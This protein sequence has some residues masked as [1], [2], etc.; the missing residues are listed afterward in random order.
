MLLFYCRFGFVLFFGELFPPSMDIVLVQW[1]AYRL[2][3][4][5]VKQFQCFLFK[6]LGNVTL[7]GCC[8]PGTLS[9]EA[10]GCYLWT[11]FQSKE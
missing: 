6:L 11:V 3:K 9:T 7:A 8:V 5:H 1:F 4:G 10:T 2:M